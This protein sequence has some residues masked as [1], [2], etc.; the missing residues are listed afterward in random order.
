[1]HTY[2][3]KLDKLSMSSKFSSWYDWLSDASHPAFGARLVYVTTRC[4]MR[5][6]RQYSDFTVDHRYISSAPVVIG[7][8]S[9]MTSRAE[10]TLRSRLAACSSS[11][12]CTQHSN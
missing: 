5:P 3:D 11:I 12:T 7:P 4:V 2:I 10:P 9:H 8:T 6:G 1:M